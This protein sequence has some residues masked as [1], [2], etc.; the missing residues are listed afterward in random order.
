MTN[1]QLYIAFA[2][3]SVL[4]LLGV[5]TSLITFFVA[6]SGF[7]KRLDDFGKRLD[8]FRADMKE[9]FARMERRFEQIEITQQA[10]RQDLADIKIE[11][12]GHD[13]EIANLK[14]RVK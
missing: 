6:N 10:M 1:A 12:R 8:D 3:P 2:I 5:L 9:G 13:V 4:A 11:L 7:N 14:E